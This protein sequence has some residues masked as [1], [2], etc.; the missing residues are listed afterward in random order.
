MTNRHVEIQ[1]VII[2]G[3]QY[4]IPVCKHCR[5][6]FRPSREKHTLHCTGCDATYTF[7]SLEGRYDRHD[8]SLLHGDLGDTDS[9][10]YPLSG[11]PVLPILSFLIMGI[12]YFVLKWWLF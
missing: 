9:H 12:E 2:N 8:P 7:K 5:S 11:D 6:P 3:V 4:F 1:W 10:T